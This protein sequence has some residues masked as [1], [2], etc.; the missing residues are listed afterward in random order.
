[1]AALY[2]FSLNGNEYCRIELPVCA[3]QLRPDD[4]AL[5]LEYLELVRR[6]LHRACRAPGYD[7]IYLGC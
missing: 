2:Q 7:P 3:S 6:Q 4:A 5:L 1:M